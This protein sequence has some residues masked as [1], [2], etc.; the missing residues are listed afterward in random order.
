MNEINTPKENKLCINIHNKE[1]SKF[2]LI[3]I[4]KEDF[5]SFNIDKNL[6]TFTYYKR[7]SHEVKSIDINTRGIE[8]FFINNEQVKKENI[9]K[10]ITKYLLL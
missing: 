2:F 7:D 8:E 9:N 5:I 10:V 6:I 4:L 1:W 3:Y